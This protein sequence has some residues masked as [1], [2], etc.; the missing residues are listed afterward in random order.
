M[1]SLSLELQ[2]I[3]TFYRSQVYRVKG[4]IAIPESPNR[5]ILQSARSAFVA[6]DGS[7]WKEG[8]KRHGKLVFIGRELRKEVFQKMFNRYLIKADP[9]SS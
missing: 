2:R 3:V 1:N 9:I 5:V 6:T 4:I 7:P 8:E